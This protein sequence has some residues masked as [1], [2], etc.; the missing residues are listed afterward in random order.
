[1][2]PDDTDRHALAIDP[3]SDTTPTEFADTL[4]RR[5]A[6]EDLTRYAPA[7]LERLA[8]SALAHVATPRPAGPDICLS[9]Y[10]FVT[11]GRVSEVT[12]LEVV[13]DNMPFL[14]DSTLAELD[15]QGWEPQLVAHPILA[16]ERDLRGT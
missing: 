10:E 13:N 9:D 3:L 8:A 6:R 14:L 12:V 5:S 11:D 7:D 4:F 1:M 15:A 2:S 16:V